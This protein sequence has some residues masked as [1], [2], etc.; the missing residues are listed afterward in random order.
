MPGGLKE[1][2]GVMRVL[3]NQHPQAE[4]ANFMA[5]T[6]EGSH[7]LSILEH[8]RITEGPCRVVSHNGRVVVNLGLVWESLA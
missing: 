1:N 6:H 2:D 4:A 3:Y 8:T 7:I 5:K